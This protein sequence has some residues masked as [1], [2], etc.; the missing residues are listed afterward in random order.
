MNFHEKL[1]NYVHKGGNLIMQYN[2]ASRSIRD[3]EFGPY[4]FKLSRKRVTE[5]DATVTFLCPDHP[6]LNLPNK[7]TKDD[8]EGWVQERG[9]YFA[10]EWDENYTPLFSW[11][12]KGEDPVLGGLIVAQYGKGQFVYTGISFFRELPKGV[13]GAYRLFANLLSYKP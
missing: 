1:L 11:S 9:L 3:N 10:G 2:T 13:V 6:I 5:E 12:D 4:P 7:I 8:F